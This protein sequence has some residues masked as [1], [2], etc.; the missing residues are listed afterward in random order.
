MQININSSIKYNQYES[1]NKE[2]TKES[3]IN[4]KSMIEEIGLA[5]MSIIPSDIDENSKVQPATQKEY[6][7]FQMSPYEVAKR[8]FYQK[9]SELPEEE[10]YL[11]PLYFQDSQRENSHSSQL[12]REWHNH[13]KEATIKNRYEDAPEFEAFVNKWMTKGESREIAEARA[14]TYAEFGLLDYGKQRATTIYRGLPVEDIKQHGM[15]LIDNPPLKEALI[16]TLDSLDEEGCFTLYSETFLGGSK[17]QS[18]GLTFKE[19]LQRYGMELADIEN[20]KASLDPNYNEPEFTFS[21]D[22]T[23][24]NDGTPESQRYNDSIFDTLINFFK[25]SIDSIDGLNKTF[26][27]GKGRENAAKILIDNYKEFYLKSR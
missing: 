22:I 27:E 26:H 3:S 21:G 16:K 8:E 20:M 23:M 19:V 9:Q 12:S 17:Y 18:E 10:R 15:W 4:F 14:K 5:P 2:D 7:P 24:K 11:M 1:T 25:K 13:I 6:H